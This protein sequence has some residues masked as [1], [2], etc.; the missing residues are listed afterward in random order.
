MEQSL[1]VTNQK[2]RI[3]VNRLQTNRRTKS[4]PCGRWNRWT[5]V[6]R[7][8]CIF[9][10]RNFGFYLLGKQKFSLSI[11]KQ[12][13]L[14]PFSNK[15][16]KSTRRD[17]KSVN[18]AI[19]K[20]DKKQQEKSGHRSTNPPATDS[21]KLITP[22]QKNRSISQIKPEKSN[23]Q[24]DKKSGRRHKNRS[25]ID[26]K[27]RQFKH[28]TAFFKRRANK[29]ISLSIKINQWHSSQF[30]PEIKKTTIHLNA[31]KASTIRWMRV[32]NKKRFNSANSVARKKTGWGCSLG[33]THVKY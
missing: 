15:R 3:F 33:D 21:K 22:G 1:L 8:P 17:K 26:N 18:T 2:G 14:K 16:K 27:T 12:N 5:S 20:D 6:N 19:I 28:Q 10:T 13:P 11:K 31:S 24:M 4:D 9:Q 25:T 23:K 7:E 32:L 30:R 29:K